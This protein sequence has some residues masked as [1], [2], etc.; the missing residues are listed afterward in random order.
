[1]ELLITKTC[2]EPQILE[3]L[4]N[5]IVFI[6]NMHTFYLGEN[7]LEAAVFHVIIF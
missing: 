5:V 7:I 1:M 2:S 6:H 4:H 3:A